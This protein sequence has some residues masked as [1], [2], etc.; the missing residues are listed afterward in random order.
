MR[1]PGVHLRSMLFRR[2]PSGTG[3]AVRPPNARAGALT[4]LANAVLV[5]AALAQ[6]AVVAYFA[7]FYYW[8]GERQFVSGFAH[9]VYVGAPAIG[10]VL[11]IAALKLSP[12]TRANLALSLVS[13]G[14]SIYAVEFAAGFWFSLPS[15]QYAENLKVL[16]AAAAA[17]GYPFDSRSTIDVIRDLRQE[18]KDAVPSI[19]PRDL[20]TERNGTVSSVIRDRDTELLP[21]AGISQKPTVACNEGDG[22]LVYVSDEHGFHN[23]PGLWQAPIV[24]LV[25]VGDSFTHGWCVQSERNFVSRIR[26]H[27]PITLNLGMAA[28]G[29]LTM[30]AT[31]REYGTVLKPRTVLWFY[32]EGNDLGDL[33]DERDSALLRRYLND[34]YRQRLIERQPEIDIALRRYLDGLSPT[35]AIARELSDALFDTSQWRLRLGTTVKLST[36]RARLNLVGGA[37]NPERTVAV[38]SDRSQSMGDLYELFAEVLDQAKRSVESWG[39]RMYFVYLPARTEYDP[40][41]RQPN[42]DRSAVLARAAAVGLP[43]ID[44]TPV[45]TEA[46]DPMRFFPFRMADHYNEAGH[47]LVARTVLSRLSP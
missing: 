15:V 32:F 45:L 28:N 10:G 27:H 9:A 29:P 38:P 6:F 24:D 25:G 26:E 46:G 44:I 21:L 5:A 19:I 3:P 20:L 33:R 16:G 11:L 47:E 37:A 1:R 36:L 7:Y 18:G 43:V 35:T 39:G 41:D 31:L 8:T 14:F 42:P 2:T 30:L 34:G 23:P 40:R 13:V 22:Y 12:E 17:H 4:T